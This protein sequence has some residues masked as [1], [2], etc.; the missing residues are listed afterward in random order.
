MK[1]FLII[2]FVSLL[3]TTNM[4]HYSDLCRD[5]LYKF[6]RQ[7][8]DLTPAEESLYKK[9]MLECAILANY[10]SCYCPTFCYIFVPTVIVDKQFRKYLNATYSQEKTYDMTNYCADL[11]EK[12]VD[13]ELQTRARRLLYG[14]RAEVGHP[15]TTSRT[16]APIVYVTSALLITIAL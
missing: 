13:D 3:T 9:M 16:R 1:L 7:L 14:T 4:R 10:T 5:L 12:M 11:Y 2:A 8:S 15:S 6:E